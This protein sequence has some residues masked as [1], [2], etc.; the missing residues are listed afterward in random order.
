MIQEW[1]NQDEF[2]ACGCGSVIVFKSHHKY[3]PPKYILG[4]SGK[5]NIGNKKIIKHGY[6]SILNKEKIKCN[7]INCNATITYHCFKYGGGKCKSCSK[8]NKRN[9]NYKNLELH[10]CKQCNKEI[11]NNKKFCNQDCLCK[12]KHNNPQNHW[13]YKGG[14]CLNKYSKEFNTSL[15]EFI[16]KRDN[17]TCQNCGISEKKHIKKYKQKLHI[18]HINKMHTIKYNLITLCISCHIK[19]NRNNLLISSASYFRQAEINDTKQFVSFFK[20]I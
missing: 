5:L 7:E 19:E 8:K 4:H 15:K 12:Y 2:C 17:Y 1:N 11:P 14:A 10:Y 20:Y 6:Y 16:R 9:P 13:N 3:R 18:H